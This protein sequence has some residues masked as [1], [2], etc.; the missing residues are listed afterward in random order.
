MQFPERKKKTAQKLLEVIHAGVC[1]P[2]E[3][4]SVG[5][6]KYFLVLVD[7]FSKMCFVYFMKS[8]D[9]VFEHFK[10]FITISHNHKILQTDTSGKFCGLDFQQFLKR[11]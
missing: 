10:D 3:V 9:E 7:D 6:S 2:M 5:G 11:D 8:K 4:R 1:R